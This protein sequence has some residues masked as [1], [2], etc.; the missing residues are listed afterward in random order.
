MKRTKTFKHTIKY[1]WTSETYTHNL[2]LVADNYQADGSL[3]II[4]MEEKEDGEDEQF[5]VITTCLPWGCADK[6]HAYIDTNNCSW[7]EKMLKQHRIAK[8]TDIWERSGYCT[9]PLYEFNLTKFYEAE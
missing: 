1:S 4:V 3:A 8:D 2:Y 5:D 9:Y 6:S 7:A